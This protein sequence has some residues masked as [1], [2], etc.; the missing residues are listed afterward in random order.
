MVGSAFMSNPISSLLEAAR[1]TSVGATA[2]RLWHRHA[3][4]FKVRRRVFGLT[5]YFDFRDNAVWW[6]KDAKKLEGEDRS[7]EILT[8]F[9]GTV[10]DVGANVGIFALRAA[11][12]GHRV[13]AFEI[14]KKALNLLNLSAKAN[15]LDII[16]VH[17]AFSIRSFSYKEPDSSDTENAITES[18]EGKSLSITYLEA[19][20]EFP[21]PDLLKM[22]IEGGEKEFIQSLEF[23]RW[24]LENR[25]PWVVESH[26]P[27]FESLLWSDCAFV[28]LDDNHFG[29]NLERVVTKA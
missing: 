2:A 1:A 15:K 3:P 7:W 26:S 14:S 5:M 27:E 9:K 24:I 18:K 4:S 6:T 28:R 21:M 12:L 29:L 11:S 22:D 25:I 17:R 19:A 10:W 16:T 13:I 23:K 20:K 8:H